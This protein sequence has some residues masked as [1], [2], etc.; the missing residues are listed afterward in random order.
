MGRSD[1][2]RQVG[3]GVSKLTHETAEQMSLFEDPKWSTTG[4]VHPALHLPGGRSPRTM[5]W[6]SVMAPGRKP[7]PQRRKPSGRIRPCVFTAGGWKTGLT[8]SRS[9]RRARSRRGT[10]S[11]D[12]LLQK[13]IV[14]P[15]IRPLSLTFP[16]YY[17]SAP[18]HNLLNQPIFT[19]S[20]PFLLVAV[21]KRTRCPCSFISWTALTRLLQ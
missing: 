1:P 4:R 12:G 16:L 3:L 19:F 8:A 10:A 21:E 11:R 2:I 6:F 14:R 9:S 7:L 20:L 5:P 18:T 13:P 17:G 15:G